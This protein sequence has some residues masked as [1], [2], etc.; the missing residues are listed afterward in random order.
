[1][2]ISEMGIAQMHAM[3]SRAVSLDAP[4]S[5][6]GR[7]GSSSLLDL[8]AGRDCGDRDDAHDTAAQQLSQLMERLSH[9]ERRVIS[10]VFGLDTGEPQAVTDVADKY[11]LP[12]V[13]VRGLIQKAMAK[14]RGEQQVAA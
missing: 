10:E 8:L 3:M 6:G 7:D 13:K 12:V 2:G 1:M 14:L 5:G 9:R 11:R 4:L